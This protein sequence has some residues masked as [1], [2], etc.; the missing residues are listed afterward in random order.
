MGTDDFRALPRRDQM[1]RDR[2]AE[3]LLRLRWR[4]GSD[5]ALAR[6]ADQNR[7]AE[8]AELAEARQCNH[9]LLRR[10]AE[11]DAGVEHDFFP[12]DAG[13]G[14]DLQGSAEV[15]CNILHD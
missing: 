6:R 14:G 10:L 1:R 15:A 2:A 12:R 11:A 5:E 8:R 9:A 3:P 13:F 7:E 4:N